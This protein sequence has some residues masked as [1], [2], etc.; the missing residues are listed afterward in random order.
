M[1]PVTVRSQRTPTDPSSCILFMRYRIL[2]K[3]C[4]TWVQLT[5]CCASTV[6]KYLWDLEFLQ[7]CFWGVGY[8]GMWWD[9]TLFYWTSICRHVP[10]LSRVKLSNQNDCL[11]VVRWRHC[12][13]LQHQN[14]SY[15]YPASHACRLEPT[16]ED[17][18]LVPFVCE[19]VYFSHCSDWA[20][21]KVIRDSIPGRGK[22]FLSSLKCPDWLWGPSSL[23]FSRY[24]GCSLGVE[25][26]EE[27]SWWLTSSGAKVKNGWSCISAH[28]VC[29]CVMHKDNF[30]SLTF[31]LCV[32]HSYCMAFRTWQCLIHD[33]TSGVF[34]P[35]C[36]T[37][38]VH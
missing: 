30:S 3:L 19:S 15:N 18:Q 32:L 29:L 7:W 33:L 6:T 5:V 23:L 21:G 25:Q 38:A 8:S 11:T 1:S 13:R 2:G 31:T 36:T 12:V 17:L 10:L 24:Q 22:R 27:L 28:P 26:P 4:F 37:F 34:V 35:I 16:T 20:M 9:V 14:H